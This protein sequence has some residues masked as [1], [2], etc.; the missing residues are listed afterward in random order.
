MNFIPDNVSN[1][2]VVAVGYGSIGA[3]FFLEEE[4]SSPLQSVKYTAVRMDDAEDLVLI[5]YPLE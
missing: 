3:L 5:A 1:K 4:K 2:F